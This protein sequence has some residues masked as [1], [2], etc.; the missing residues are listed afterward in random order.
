MIDIFDP[1]HYE[2]VRR[3]LLDAVSL[4][5]WCY[6]SD[7]FYRREVEEILVK[8]WN[9][10]GRV[11]EIPHPGDYRVFD[12]CGQ[13]A[14]VMRGE[15]GEIRAL[16]NTCRHRGTRLLDDRG[17]CRAII[18]PYHAWTY[19]LDGTLFGC[20]GMEKTRG[21]DKEGNGLAPVR[22]GVWAGFIFVCF[23][24]ECPDL[25]TW[26][27][28]LPREF[29]PYRFETFALVRRKHY[30]LDCNWKLYIENAMEDY[31]TP[32]VHRS[33]IGLQE[34]DPLETIGEWDSIHMESD[35]TIAVLPED[36]GRRP[37][38]P[39]PCSI[40]RRSSAPRRSRTSRVWRDGVGVRELLH[41]PLPHD[42]LRHHEGLHVVAA[43]D[44]ER[45]GL[46]ARSSAGQASRPG[47]WGAE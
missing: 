22:L 30:D 4:P 19:R 47:C 17:N 36:T 40:P 9:L 44:P 46:R 8:S 16:A 13:S 10:V 39:S 25:E 27:G 38:A 23:S 42:V 2:G 26:L 3:P 31:H 1:R 24:D 34:T 28:D 7:A 41:R 37:G 15:D 14:I 12:L 21:F 18:C 6:T 20:R 35:G 33:S 45:P 5:P 32:T 11:D 43:D 29:G